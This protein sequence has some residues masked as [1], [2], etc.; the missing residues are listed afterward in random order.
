MSEAAVICDTSRRTLH[1]FRPATPTRGQTADESLCSMAMPAVVV[2]RRQLTRVA[3]RF[4]ECLQKTGVS[5]NGAP[6]RRRADYPM[7]LAQQLRCSGTT[8]PFAGPDFREWRPSAPGS[9]PP[10][11]N[12]QRLVLQARRICRRIVQDDSDGFQVV[13]KAQEHEACR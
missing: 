9:Q 5:A 12:P 13:D 8:E 1:S 2:R 10:K 4:A 7:G 6:W 11:A 3:D